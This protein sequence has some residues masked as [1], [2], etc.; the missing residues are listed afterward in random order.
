MA[1]REVLTFYCGGGLAVCDR[2]PAKTVSALLEQARTGKGPLL[3]EARGLE[4]D[5][6]SG[7]AAT[8]H[9]VPP[10]RAR[11]APT[12]RVPA[13]VHGRSSRHAT[14]EMRSVRGL[15]RGG[16]PARVLLEVLREGIP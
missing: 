2:L 12:T 10:A 3:V 1:R 7:S 11:L 14:K 4:A 15:A 16:G 6:A 13:E 8:R 5:V 9:V